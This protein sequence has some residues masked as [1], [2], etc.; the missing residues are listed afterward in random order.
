[1]ADIK[2]LGHACFRV[3]SREGTVLLD[4]TAHGMSVNVNKQRAD[5]VTLSDA[6][7]DQKALGVIEGEPTFVAGPGEYEV[8]DVFVTGI[9]TAGLKKTFNTVYLV[10]IDEMIF[11]HLG[12]PGG[13]LTTAQ[14]EAMGNVDVLFAPVG[15]AAFP[16]AQVTEA[17]GQIEPRM[18]IPMQYGQDDAGVRALSEFV[19]ALGKT[20]VPRDDKLIIRKGNLPD[21]MGVTVLDL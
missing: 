5:I 13:A 20:D 18:V 19:A 8:S 11:G 1:M 17:I 2:W 3:K 14:V 4:P 12:Y 7:A 15:S 16:L 9:R 21:T 6:T 10:E